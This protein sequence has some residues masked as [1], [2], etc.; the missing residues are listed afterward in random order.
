MSEFLGHAPKEK[1]V[2]PGY[3]SQYAG[4]HWLRRIDFDGRPDGLYVF[5]WQPQAQLWCRPNEYAC[6]LDL[7]L[8]GYEYLSPCPLPLD[9]EEKDEL[10]KVMDDLELRFTS[11]NSV[12]VDR[13]MISMDQYKILERYFRRNRLL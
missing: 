6:G 7:D 2:P 4:Y 11:G 1:P 13:A 3:L 9:V 12:P 8:I 10:R 5:Q